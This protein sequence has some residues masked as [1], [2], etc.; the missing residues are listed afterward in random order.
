MKVL[1]S[2][3]QE[4]APFSAHPLAL[5]ES[6]SALGMTVESV[7]PIGHGL[8][9]IVVARVM[10]LRPHPDADR[11][12]RVDVD[13]GDGKALQVW[14]GAFNLAVGDLVPL[15][16]IGT[17]MPNG[18]EISRR[19]ILG[20]YSDGMLCSAAELGLGHDAD[21]IY[22]LPT[23]L[24]PG[25]KMRDALGLDVDTVY[26]LEINPN[27]PDAMSVVGV[28]RDLAGYHRVPFNAPVP[29]AGGGGPAIGELSSV[30]VL[31]R[32]RCGRF[33]ARVLHGVSIGPSPA[34]LA[35]RLVL[36]GMRPINNVVDVSNYVMLELGAPTHAYDLARLGQR[37]L[38]VRRAAN[39]EVLTTLDDVERRLCP[40]DLVICDGDDRPVGIAGIMGGAQAE[41]G[42]GTEDVLVEVAWW[43]PT[44]IARTARRLGLRTEASA[45]FER[46][47]D[48]EG[49][50]HAAD[51]FVELLAVDAGTT[52]TGLIDER[53]TTPARVPIRLRTVKTNATLGTNLDRETI[54]RYLS[55]I[56]YEVGPIGDEDEDNEVLAP[57]FRP[58]VVAEIDVIEEVA[59]HHG[60]ER[61][62]RVVPP[63]VHVGS[64]TPRQ[65]RRR[66]V[67]DALVGLG[68]NEAMPMPFLAPDDLVRAGLPTAAVT[69]T[70]PLVVEESV[71][72]TSLLPGLLAVL[73]YNASH[74]N[75]GV[76]LWEIG[77]VFRRPAEPAPLPEER[78][79]LG[80]ALAGSEAPAAVEVLAVVL[81]AL[82]LTH[83]LVAQEYPGLH[84]SR[85][86]TVVVQG[87]DVGA[88]GEVG[89]A[90]L[91]AH[92]IGERVAWLEV[93]LGL[94]LD[95]APAVV[96]YRPVSRY[97]SSDV[98]L[99]FDVD[100]A[101]PASALR[102]TLHDAAGDLA[103]GLELFD[104]YRG[105]G[106]AP[107]R[108][109]LA[110]R[111]RLQAADRTLT[112]AEVAEVRN[113]AVAAAEAGHP[114]R[115]R[116]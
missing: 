25:A 22:I 40:D 116:A 36:V 108:R 55:A 107:G 33:V 64:L 79:H 62:G 115:L 7:A 113:R 1:Y 26:D 15:A 48:P 82:D 24:T 39:E 11:V 21:G 67:R 43:E 78:E 74:R 97:P 30:E 72:R 76:E 50:V 110:Y 63:T 29:F 20:E 80:V 52:A 84:P 13:P 2:W 69:I 102:R 5:A 111:L 6:M 28:A 35:N 68:L 4:F 106:V 38:R 56:G 86:A 37:R 95:A 75:H 90:V 59:R 77:Q 85:S 101:V 34:W 92:T 54:E 8:D 51:R 71:L 46:G 81:D 14:C 19:K 61:I 109:S 114:A 57:S 16:T 47:T 99:A 88:V 87:R 45:R 104:V 53:G 27:R 98:D 100:D 18:M 17:E 91:E 60:Y 93:N 32:E 42:A 31:D 96:T 12:Q 23:G 83:E 66:A 94:L 58:D 10:A 3:L 65:R 41:I 103:V 112:D 44:A 73:S 70:N 49:L 105:E 9:G 89:P